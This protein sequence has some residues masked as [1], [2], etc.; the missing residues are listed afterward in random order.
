MASE[1]VCKP[2]L[3]MRPENPVY[4]DSQLSCDVYIM[5][6]EQGFASKLANLEISSQMCMDPSMVC[7]SSFQPFAM[8]APLYLI[9][10]PT[11]PHDN[12]AIFRHNL[13]QDM[14]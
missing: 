4:I 1:K 13:Q 9:V 8:I 6:F 10:L 2:F 12:S 14:F 5:R 7:P 11:K 3:E